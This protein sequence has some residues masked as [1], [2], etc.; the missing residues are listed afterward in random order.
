MDEKDQ[1]IPG[2]ARLSNA[3]TLTEEVA[4]KSPGHNWPQINAD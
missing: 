3:R 1:V 2:A 4:E